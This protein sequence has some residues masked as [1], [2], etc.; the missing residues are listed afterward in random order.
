MHYIINYEVE[1]EDIITQELLYA[2]QIFDVKKLFSGETQER[3]AVTV[4]SPEQTVSSYFDEYVVTGGHAYVTELILSRIDPE[5]KF[6][7]SLNTSIFFE[8]EKNIYCLA[9]PEKLTVIIPNQI[10]QRQYDELEKYIQQIKELTFEKN[11]GVEYFINDDYL[12]DNEKVDKIIQKYKDIITEVESKEYHIDE[13]DFSECI[14][15]MQIMDKAQEYARDLNNKLGIES[16]Q[17]KLEVKE[18]EIKSLNSD[19]LT[20]EQFEAKVKDIYQCIFENFCYTVNTKDVKS[21]VDLF[22]KNME[23][24]RKKLEEYIDNHIDDDPYFIENLDHQLFDIE[25]ILEET[26]YNEQPSD[27][28]DYY[29]ICKKIEKIDIYRRAMNGEIDEE[30]ID[31]LINIVMYSDSMGI[32]KTNKQNQEDIMKILKKYGYNVHEGKDGDIYY[33]ETEMK[34]RMQTPSKGFGI[35]CE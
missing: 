15:D 17:E 34:R 1:D 6:T 27:S 28:E 22:N 4:I 12:D 3:Y 9:I 31:E 18:E 20:Q 7:K 11:K 23:Y 19:N 32:Y 13:Y 14:D 25:A 33:N 2:N 8:N 30:I 16:Q 5:Y 10:N 24:F 26:F 29:K 35:E 21:R